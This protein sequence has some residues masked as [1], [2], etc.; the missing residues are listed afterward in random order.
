MER[1]FIYVTSDGNWGSAD[2]LVIFNPADLPLEGVKL[3]WD[4]LDKDDG[5]DLFWY[6]NQPA[7]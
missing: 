1:N 2:D 4:M 7:G 5:A 6:L 3:Y